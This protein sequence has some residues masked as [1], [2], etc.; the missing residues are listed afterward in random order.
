VSCHGQPLSGGATVRLLAR[1][2]LTATSSVDSS[3]SVA[4][5]SVVRM[6][7]SVGAMP[8]APAAPIAEVRIAAFEAWVTSGTPA[9]TCGAASPDGGQDAGPV[10][11]YD[12]G[13]AGLPCGVASFVAQKCASCH[14]SPP[15]GGA[16]FPLL[17]RADFLAASPTWA[18]QTVGQRSSARLHSSTSPM[19]PAGQ[20]QATPS[21]IS[22]FDTWVTGG[23]PQGTC[24]AVDAGSSDAGPSPTTCASASYWTGGDTASANM[25]PGKACR[26]CHA[27]RAPFKNYPYAGTVF[28]GLHEQD[29]C[30]AHPPAGARIDI[31]DKNGTVLSL[32]PSATSGNFHSAFVVSVVTPYTAR[33]TANGHT[34]TMTTPQTNGDCNFCHTEQGANGAPGRLV[35]PP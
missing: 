4:Q 18:G 6:R 34:S 12:G 19:P 24:G 14:R 29:L 16:S 5:R 33:I 32:T 22:A 30:N 15:T 10:T 21:E 9:G 2:D 35:W 31:I 11:A 1:A 20:P 13:V 27:T 8:P 26:Q 7:Q 25:N 3:K 17:A 28:P 23:M